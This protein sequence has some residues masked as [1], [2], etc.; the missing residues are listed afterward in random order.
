MSERRQRFFDSHM[1]IIDPRFPLVPNQGF[2][3]T[4]FIVEDYRART[5]EFDVA[6]GV[7]VSGSFQGFDQT[8]LV[9]ALQ[10]LGYGFVGVTQLPATVSDDEILSLDA[11]GARAVRFNLHRGGSERL[12]M[13]EDLGRR[14]FDLARWHVELYVDSRDLGELEDRLLALPRVSIDHLGLSPDGFPVLLRLVEHGVH[15][16]ATGFGRV[17]LDV[18]HAMRAICAVN[19]SALMFGTDLPSTRATR[20]FEDTDVA[21]VVDTLGEEL[22]RKVLYE[23]GLAFYR[24]R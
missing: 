14:V 12:D 23:N 24:A 10:R 7:V 13:L 19:P 15:V 6:G 22:G 3:P 11:A 8:Y 2:L 1:H 9:D 17:T 21:L 16:K 18:A 5:A 20:P 4:S